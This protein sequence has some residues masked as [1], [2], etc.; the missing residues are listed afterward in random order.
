[1]SISTEELLDAFIRVSDRVLVLLNGLDGRGNEGDL[2]SIVY[3]VTKLYRI[4][5]LLDVSTGN[6]GSDWT[7]FEC[8]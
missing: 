1:M 5:R 3:Q 6:T 8:I 2:D 4:A 7:K